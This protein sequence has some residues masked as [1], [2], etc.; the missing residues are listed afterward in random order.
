MIEVTQAQNQEVA[1]FLEWFY[2]GGPWGLSAKIDNKQFITRVFSDKVD[3]LKFITEHNGVNNMYLA[4]NP[5]IGGGDDKKSKKENIKEMRWV[6]V[7]IDTRRGEDIPTDLIRIR[8]LLTERWPDLPE[9]S[10]IVFS[11][12]YY[13]VLWRLD[14]PVPVNGDEKLAEELE[15]YNV[16]IAQILEGDACHNL[17]RVM[18]L[19][20]TWNFPDERKLRKGRKPELSTIFK[21]NDGVH[22]LSKFAKAAPVQSGGT[23][24]FK[25][26]EQDKVVLSGNVARVQDLEELRQYN[27]NDRTLV[28]I[29]GG[30]AGAVEILGPKL[31]GKDNSRSGWLFEGVCSMVRAKVPDETIYAILMDPAWGISESI[32]DKENPHKHAVHTIERAKAVARDPILAEM[33]AQFAVIGSIG[34]K[35]RIIEEV[36]DH[37]LGRTRLVKQ[38]F[39]DFANRWKHKKVEMMG[40]DGPIYVPMGKWWTEHAERR[41]YDSIVF[42]PKRDPPNV[43]NL[44]RGFAVEPRPGSCDL[45][46][47]HLRDVVC[48]GNLEH[49]EYLLDWMAWAV[50]EPGKAGEVAVVLRGDQ[51]TGK[52]LT[53]KVFGHLFGRHFLQISDS[54]HLTG[55][56]NVHLRD[57]V[58]VFAD[59]AF[60]AGDKKHESIL[61]TLVTEPTIMIEGKGVDAEVAPNCI[62]LMMAS[63]SNWVVPAGKH[64]RRYFVLDVKPTHRQD[65]AYF[66]AMIKQMNEGGY[67]ALLLMLQTRPVSRQRIQVAPKTTALSHQQDFTLSYE[68][69]WWFEKLQLGELFPGQ[70]WPREVVKDDLYKDWLT[71][72][73]N[74]NVYRRLTETAWNL[75]INEVLAEPRK[76]QKLVRLKEYDADGVATVRTARKYVIQLPDV[77]TARNLWTQAHGPRSWEALEVTQELELEEPPPAPEQRVPF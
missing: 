71:H 76:I 8:G 75:F 5:S 22:S 17:D 14:A 38:T 47:A 31:E 4:I 65:T 70:G 34:G 1:D 16:R 20:G 40:K 37:A 44:W 77:H 3:A 39:E 69:S 28:I 13:W 12:G 63:N 54:K 48:G 15:L 35:C 33:N 53:I 23:L 51:G 41:Q 18:R 59:E 55:N 61:K 45:Y 2:P 49:Y 68:E 72:A 67:N 36:E 56:F 46:L 19:P 27:L 42:L 62:H 30:Q 11:G 25:A 21:Q 57:A 64:E 24:G 26:T 9:P 52:G 58:V 29:Q 43:Y 74:L 60:Y 50:Q 32:I 7:D 73:K 10:L 6:H 66:G